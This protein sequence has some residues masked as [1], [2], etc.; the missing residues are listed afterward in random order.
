MKISDMTVLLTGACGGI[1]QAL[2]VELANGGANLYLTGR[3][4]Q[5]LKQLQ[6]KLLAT[7][8][9]DQFILVD[10]IDL[11]S[12]EARESMARRL[13]RLPKPVNTLINNAGMLS[14]R[15]FE[16]V[17]PDEIDRVMYLNSVV[18]MKLTHRLLPGFK[19]LPEARIVN[20][21]STFGAIGFPGYS[22]Y[23]ASKFAVRGFTE[24][25][26]RELADSNVS[27]GCFLPRATQ[28]SINTSKVVALNE[29]LRVTMDAPENVAGALVSFIAGK[30]RMQ[31]LGWPEKLLVKL[32][33]VF[34]VLIGN[35]I[36]KKLPIIKRYA[37]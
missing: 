23:S 27:V 33:S 3:N 11:T 10:V 16:N 17:S 9:A 8:S 34:P 20:I 15:L 36:E 7:A 31:A 25:L 22:I 12:D 21:A 26:A 35:A 1:G 4:E 24:A 2:A 28:T 14:F 6:R 30:R 5:S 32:N 13:E 29:E 18:T 37:M 19:S